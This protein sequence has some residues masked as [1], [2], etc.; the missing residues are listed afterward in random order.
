MIFSLQ[1]RLGFLIVFLLSGV[2][3]VATAAPMPVSPSCSIGTC[4]DITGWGTTIVTA[5]IRASGVSGADSVTLIATGFTDGPLRQGSIQISALNG[6]VATGYGTG[7]LDLTIGSYHCSTN[8]EFQPCN[9]WGTDDSTSYL[10][11]L[12][13]TDFVIRLTA[14]Y[15]AA[16]LNGSGAA[17]AAIALSIF[18]GLT[19]PG[20]SVLLPGSAV[21]IYDALGVAAVAAPEPSTL[22]FGATVLLLPLLWRTRRNLFAVTGPLPRSSNG[23]SAQG[24]VNQ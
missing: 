16:G 23:R 8:S 7:A 11:F 6:L 10:P 5:G 12:L 9:L 4:S 2:F 14:S 15:S 22:V 3:S 13:G 18:D 20:G 17:S 1:M 24:S 19:L 21:P